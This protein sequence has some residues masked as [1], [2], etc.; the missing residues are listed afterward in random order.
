[1]ALYCL[2]HRLITMLSCDKDW[3]GPSCRLLAVSWLLWRSPTIVRLV[4]GQDWR[5]HW[6][7]GGH[8][9][10]HHMAGSSPRSSSDADQECHGVTS[11]HHSS[12]RCPPGHPGHCIVGAVQDWSHLSCCDIAMVPH[13]TPWTQHWVT[14]LHC[15]R[16]PLHCDQWHQW[17]PRDHVW[18]QD[19]A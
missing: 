10:C 18:V 13:S 11:S 1:M 19:S 3:P 6:S 16:R 4:S 17:Q 15:D 14:P 12:G 5:G 7:G 2:D 8:E 9:W